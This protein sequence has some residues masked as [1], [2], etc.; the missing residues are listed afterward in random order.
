VSASTPLDLRAE[1]IRSQEQDLRQR[2]A[3]FPLR[4]LAWV[5][6]LPAWTAALGARLGLAGASEPVDGLVSR[7]EAADLIDTR[8]ILD[9]DGDLTESFWLRAAIRP[10]LGHYLQQDPQA[11]LDQDLDDL[12]DA[13]AAL[14]SESAAVDSLGSAQWLRVIRDYRPDHTGLR[15]VGEIDSLVAQGQLAVASGLVAAA[16]SLGELASGTLLDAARRAQWR[17]D[18]A[19]RI[20]QD[21]LRLRHYCSR[22]AVEGAIEDLMTDPG[23]KWALHLLGGGGVGKTM[24]VRY[25]ASGRF[26]AERER[27][28][29]FL[30]ARADFD[31]L[32][33][34]YPEQRP[35]EL[36]MALAAELE[37]FA[38]TRELYR[39]YRRFHDAA[40][41]LHETRAGQA[42]DD[43]SGMDLLQE[44]ANRFAQFVTSLDSP[45]L[46]VLDTCEE[47]AKLY[48]PGT[49]AP[50]IDETFRLLELVHR[51]APDVRVLL[52]GRR[53]LVPA[54]DRRRRASGPLLRPRPY[55]RVLPVGGFTRA[56]A[57]AYIEAR[58][59][60]RLGE[61]P[62]SARL[63]PALRQALLERAAEEPVAT[64]RYSPF[65]LAAYYEWASNDPSLDAE[66]LRS[67]PGDPYVEWRIVGRL[68][69]D[70]VRAA[71]GV[72]AEFGRF[73]RAL[74][75]P[76]LA[77]AGIDPR[78]AFGGLAAQEWV[79]VLSLGADGGPDVIEIDEYLRDRIR[80]V[81]AGRPDDFPLD[82]VRLGQDARH[83][84]ESTPLGDL[85]AETV[86]AA[87]RLLP[88]LSAA[89]LW[90]WIED[91]ATEEHE[92][93]W[94]A[95]VAARVGAVELARAEEQG[96]GSPTILAAIIAT[97]AAARL[98]TEPGLD[99][100]RLWRAVERVARRHPDVDARAILQLR[101]RLGRLAAGDRPDTEVLREPV[102]AGLP[103]REPLTGAIVA[104]AQGCVARGEDPPEDIRGLLAEFATPAWVSSGGA[105][106][107]AA[108]A[109]LVHAVLLLWAGRNTAAAAEAERAVMAA[110][111]A[112]SGP[113]RQW[114]DWAAPR[115]LADQ[116]RLARIII[117][118]RSGA[119]ID[120]LPWPEWRSEALEHAADI[121]AE[122][123]VAATVRF[124]LG[125]RPIP[126]EELERLEPAGRYLLSRRRPSAWAHR[127]V[128]PL[129]VELA[130]AWGVLGEPERSAGLL[131]E[132][133]EAAVAA[134]DDPDSIEECEL[135]LLRLCRRQ[136]TTEYSSS[137]HRLSMQGSPRT[138]RE[139]WVVRTLVDGAQPRHPVDAGSWSTWWQCQDAVSLASLSADPP[140][141]PDEATA[142]ERAEF[143]DFFPRL[144]VTTSSPRSDAPARAP[145]DFD[146]ES[147]LRLGR[148]L[149]LP[150]GALGRA[151]VSVDELTA[152]RFPGRAAPQ[153]AAAARQLHLA[154]DTLGA[155]EAALLAGLAA[156]R[157][158]D[159]SG[160]EAAWSPEDDSDGHVAALLRLSF[161]TGWHQ[162]AE[163]LM[164]YQQRQPPSD[165]APASP[166]VMLPAADR[167]GPVQALVSLAE[168]S[169]G[170][171]VA[172]GGGVVAVAAA[173][174]A[175]GGAD[176]GTLLGVAG[177]IAL[178]RLFTV[179]LPYRFTRV[180]A[181]RVSLPDASQAARAQVVRSH[182]VRDLNGLGFA[183]IGGAL[184]GRWPFWPMFLPWRGSWSQTRS[185]DPVPAFDLAGLRL[186]KRAGPRRLS[187]IG[188]K[189][190]SAQVQ[191]L[192][193]EQW[194][195]AAAPASQVPTLL[196]FRTVSGHPPALS[197]ARW[198]TA[199]ALYRGPRHL[200][201][202]QMRRPQADREPALRILYVVS[203]PVL[204][205]AGWR[206]RV[207]EAQDRPAESSSRGR[208]AGEEL[209]SID[210]FPLNRTPLVV[211]Q[212]D[213]VDGFQQPLGDLRAGFMG[214]AQDLLDGGVGA[215]LVI[216][217]LLDDVG[218][219]VARTAWEAVA[220]RRR[221]VSP[222]TLLRT[223]ARVKALIAEAEPEAD[224]GER[225]VLD[226]LLF[227]RTAAGG[228][229]NE[230]ASRRPPTSPVT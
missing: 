192:P 125:H 90:Q 218:R 39:L 141:P 4:V 143:A 48:T 84:I 161:W 64:G 17:I 147:E 25:L 58:E 20:E 224:P 66:Q 101:A 203:T 162:R 138:Q 109:H 10:E 136:R 6:A 71:L 148:E 54:G 103:S 156:A 183:T 86:E 68:G 146:P 197:R 44:V 42:Y 99:N 127:Q 130:Q 220:E 158:D 98:Q 201:P 35:A 1:L 207:S 62:G 181:I 145:H 112:A 229:S 91:Q 154:G 53:W 118:W 104:A 173:I 211:L 113:D 67:A 29:P 174:A 230:P 87:I 9:A 28:R 55:L 110:D 83:V 32:D 193:W 205:T 172:V 23:Q 187:I 46:L 57:D 14:D 56:E 177:I 7:L 61:D 106:S 74:V 226:V 49:R 179:W 117:A 202:G 204:T 122:R 59:L 75:T 11:R 102:W 119:A 27:M 43:G 26:A 45:V 114:A 191:K 97:Q 73:D 77:R 133:L 178:L 209:L 170:E 198:R 108:A 111:N 194:L 124:E 47:L 121:D 200:L 144:G 100:S 184:V 137:V 2:F 81:T 139:A 16:R 105:H 120:A 160:A 36:M 22:P 186:P 21:R 107:A 169:S 182:G 50:A 78:A 8:E 85:P 214:C 65:E 155:Q 153:L 152:L 3:E 115:R 79:N 166:E 92:W 40:D 131:R 151:A 18:R 163:A 150:P 80:K 15:L 168:G 196:W 221:P 129:G 167:R 212:A 149:M 171:A 60:A 34:R 88:V 180:R 188:I 134:G 126:S 228:R 199:G 225:S 123:L 206:L 33:P 96:L 159:R 175:I 195:G 116:C 142:A 41:V 227:L 38:Q 216:P 37:A 69:D 189:M 95:Q 12:A 72:A 31:H 89:R 165:A 185:F 135:A 215:V 176:I 140:L 210:Q 164:A 213:P 223:L 219:Q 157:G 52:A 5:G 76:A 24:L 94:A 217:P 132:R 63:Q 128:D 190:D 208:V 82:R 51:R 13:V 70:Q 93:G 222:T 19:Y 30:V